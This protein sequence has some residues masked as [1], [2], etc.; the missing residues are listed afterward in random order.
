MVPETTGA[1]RRNRPGGKYHCADYRHC[2]RDQGRVQI[3]RN[4]KNSRDEVAYTWCKADL[5]N[6]NVEL[7][8]VMFYR[9]VGIGIAVVTAR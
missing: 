2:L 7:R 5:C 4:L 6:E 1:A 8:Q 9:G 3:H